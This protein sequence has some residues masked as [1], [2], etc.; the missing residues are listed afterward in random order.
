[1]RMPTFQLFGN[2]DLHFAFSVFRHWRTVCQATT[3]THAKI[4]CQCTHIAVNL[5]AHSISGFMECKKVG[6]KISSPLILLGREPDHVLHICP[7][8][9]EVNPRQTCDRDCLGVLWNSHA[10]S[11]MLQLWQPT[12]LEF[13]QRVGKQDYSNHGWHSR[14]LVLFVGG[15]FCRFWRN[16][17][18]VLDSFVKE[19]RQTTG[20]W[21][22]VVG[23][24]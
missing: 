10:S 23:S 2:I 22:S 15:Q 8:E 12:W 1:M 6:Q 13:Q 16:T 11:T 3:M 18:F 24:E 14:D 7:T 21:L 17:G 5:R 20:L 4:I 9:L 19:Q